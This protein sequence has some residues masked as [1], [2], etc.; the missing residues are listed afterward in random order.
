M[1]EAG[2]ASMMVC[3]LFLKKLPFRLGALQRSGPSFGFLRRCTVL[4]TLQR[5]TRKS[6]DEVEFVLPRLGLKLS[7]A[8]NERTYKNADKWQDSA[9]RHTHLC[10]FGFTVCL[11]GHVLCT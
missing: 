3:K 11:C 7:A 2:W 8:F 4:G 9:N 6:R 1:G 10:V 5:A